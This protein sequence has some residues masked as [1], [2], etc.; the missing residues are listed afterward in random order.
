MLLRVLACW[1]LLA[2]A[3]NASTVEIPAA[4]GISTLNSL[5]GANQ[6]FATGTTGTDFGISSS[7]T[8]HTFNV[9]DAGAS[10]R[11]FVNTTTQTF[12]GAKT[13]S[14][15]VGVG[16]LTVGG[17]PANIAFHRT[18]TITSAAAATPVNCLT[19]ADVPASMSAYVTHWHAK[20][21]GA[22]GWGTTTACAIEDTSGNDFVTIAVAALT[23]AAFLV[24][25]TANT[26]AATR[27]ALSTGGASDKGIQI[28]CDQNGT[29]SDL[30]VTVSGVIK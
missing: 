5:T 24:P 22:T 16:S 4:G 15:A 10:A 29:G 9:P 17:A 19:D 13:F 27:Y 12:A 28:S 14:G 18:C 21:N 26:T 1:L 3:A 8:T 6:S 25:G 30:V 11:G 2:S 23:N 20:V 7:S